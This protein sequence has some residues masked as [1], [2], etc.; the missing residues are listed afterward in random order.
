MRI[1][2]DATPLLLRSAGVKGHIYYWLEALRRLA[3]HQMIRAFPFIQRTAGLDHE[4]SIFSPWTTYPRLAALYGVNWL[5][6]PALDLCLKG[7]DVF[8]ASNQVRH[9]PRK[10]K[11]TATIF[12]LTTTKL[13]EMHTAA[14]VQADAWF[15]ERIL[16]KADGLIAI[17]ESTRQDAIELL[18][19]P[20]EKIETVP[21]GVS[22]AYFHVPVADVLEVKEL[23][24]LSKPYA[25]SVGTVEPRK[26]LDRLLDAWLGLEPDLRQHH[27][28]VLAGPPGWKSENTLRRI[29]GAPEG[30]RYLGYVP[31]QFLPALTAGAVL[32]AYPSLY[33][34]FGLPLAQA[35]AAG[36]AT[37]TSNVSSMPEVA[38]D[39]AVLVDPFSVT[40]IRTALTRLLENPTLRERLAARG[41]ERAQNYR[42]Q[43]VARRSLLFFERIAGS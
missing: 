38:G 30:V 35:M 22:E 31:E 28:L 4:R 26:N 25:L 36:V 11:L 10:A 12:D 17:S 3:G 34:G 19:I 41:R 39:G 33:E 16:K 43:R 32:L 40:E 18:G 21:C 6:S 15:A 37:I 13:P 27:E 14:N 1:M 23:Y 5:G 8:H 29:A 24:Q 20:E 9:P 42:W 2:I 7:C